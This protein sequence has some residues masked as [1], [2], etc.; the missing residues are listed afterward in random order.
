[1]SA[2]DIS[3]LLFLVFWA[4]RGFVKGFASEIVSLTIWVSS[5]YLSIK[6]F[7]IPSE[8]INNY[9]L[10]DEISSILTI[11]TIFIITFIVAAI[12]GFIFSKI[13]NIV[14][15][16]NYNKVFGLIFGSLKGFVFLTFFVFIIYQTDLKNYYLIE[17]SQFMPIIQA[18]LEKYAQTSNSL[19]DSLE[20]KI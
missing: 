17:D 15:L 14:G 16:Y 8:L 19:F 4:I 9:I 18:F 11:I 3:I 13:I 12:L 2:L 7:H 1:M 5:V 20:L 6:Y 10:S